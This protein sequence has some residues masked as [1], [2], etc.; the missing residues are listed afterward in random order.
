MT[1][2]SGLRSQIA[3]SLAVM[4][5][6][7]MV[8]SI[9]GSYAFYAWAS[10]YAPTMLSQSWLPSGAELAWIVMTVVAAVVISVWVAIR[11]SRRILNPL[12]AAAHGLR[13]IARGNLHAR[14]ALG[15]HATGET[16]QLAQDV[17]ALAERLQ[18]AVQEQ[19]FWNAAV[20]HELRTPVTILRGRLQGLVDGVFAPEPAV[21]AGLLKQAESLSRLVED[22][23]V[24]SLQDS[25]HFEIELVAVDLAL[26]LQ[27]VAESFSDRLAVAGFELRVETSVP[28]RVTCD[29]A[30]IRQALTAL[31]DNALKHATPGPLLLY[32]R[33]V[34][35]ETCVGVVDTG[36]GVPEALRQHVFDA[37]RRGDPSRSRA[38]G[39]SGLGLAVVRTIAVAHG[40]HAGCRPAP[41]RG[42]DV[43]L[44]WPLIDARQAPTHSRLLPS[45][46]GPGE[47][48]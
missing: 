5:L 42:S 2:A 43:F 26:E 21:F 27:G 1:R 22:L 20:A 19:T 18:A 10:A 47:A 33:V 7:L 39:G 17:N 3:V 28:P 24:L 46:G 32:A 36:P 48:Q 34:G 31:L 29:A 6:G 8:L 30:R 4:S 14:V 13:D 11:L 15:A 38:G 40:G 12:N 44:A 25:G 45:V 37:F 41:G 16:A 9:A 23:R 35:G